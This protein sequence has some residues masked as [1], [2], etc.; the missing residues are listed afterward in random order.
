MEKSFHLCLLKTHAMRFHI[1]IEKN[2]HVKVNCL[3]TGNLFLQTLHKADY[4]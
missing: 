3:L 4:T 2:Q 1:G